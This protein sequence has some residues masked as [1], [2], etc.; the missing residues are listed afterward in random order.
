M[1]GLIPV[2]DGHCDT[3]LLLE[4]FKSPAGSLRKNK[5]HVSLEEYAAFSPAAQFFAI[6]GEPKFLPGKDI[7][8]ALRDRF[9]SELALAGD[10]MVHC[11]TAADA[12]RA[13]A[14][15]KLAAF[16][17]VEDAA[18]IDCERGLEAAYADGVRAVNITWNHPNELSGTNAQETDRGLSEAGRSFVRRCGELGVIVDVSHLSD[19]GFWDLVDC[20]AKPFV[21]THSNARAL[22]PH[23]RNLT[24]DMF[25]ALRDIGGTA[26]LNL[27]TEFLAAEKGEPVTVET[28]VRHVEHFLD[29]DGENTVAL[30]SDFDGC[31][32]L[33]EGISGIGGWALVWEA[34]EKR[35]YSR[36]LLEKLFYRNLMRVV[37]QVC[38]T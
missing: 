35:G 26:G 7:Y 25:K 36:E 37:S 33:P 19:P 27:W 12:E 9:Y 34:L 23:P 16:L 22:C 17:S 13:A 29:L 3:L 24:D 38:N 14:E 2:F 31:S 1:I 10:R 6:F 21:A 18:L 5:L 11:R 28:C 4:F 8:T 30:G 20:S 15:G 32:T